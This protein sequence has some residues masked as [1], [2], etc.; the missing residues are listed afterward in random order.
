MD[1]L[2]FMLF[3]GDWIIRNHWR[4]EVIFPREIQTWLAYLFFRRHRFRS[5]DIM[6]GVFWRGWSQEKAHRFVNTILKFLLSLRNYRV[7]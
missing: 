3:G 1:H 2:K 7:V 4:T 6:A 5:G